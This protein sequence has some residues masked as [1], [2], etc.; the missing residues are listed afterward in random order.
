MSVIYVANDTAQR[1]TLDVDKTLK[2]NKR[3]VSNVSIVIILTWNHFAPVDL[4]H[5]KQYFAL[6]MNQ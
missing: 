4:G 1:L 5:L 6:V 2:T 3:R